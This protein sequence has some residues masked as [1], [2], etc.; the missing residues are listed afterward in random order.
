LRDG[1][2]F[3]CADNTG[4]QKANRRDADHG[5]ETMSVLVE[6]FVPFISCGVDRAFSMIKVAPFVHVNFGKSLSF[7]CSGKIKNRQ[8]ARAEQVRPSS[9]VF[10]ARPSS[11]N[12]SEP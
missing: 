5:D 4:S 6:H 9:A 12:I 10:Q 8:A 11:E 3:F 1:F 2:S 7:F